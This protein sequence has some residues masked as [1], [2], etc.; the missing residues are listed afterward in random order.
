MTF[1]TVGPVAVIGIGAYL[2][3]PQP[4]LAPAIFS[5]TEAMRVGERETMMANELREV[6]C[7]LDRSVIKLLLASA[8]VFRLNET[9]MTKVC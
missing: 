4:Q 5:S 9:T 3:W 7:M 2:A 8:Y 1:D 6:C